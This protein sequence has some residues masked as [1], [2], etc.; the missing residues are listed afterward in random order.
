M[1]KFD[2]YQIL[3]IT[4][5]LIT[6][7]AAL[8]ILLDED[9]TTESVISWLLFIFIFRWIGVIFYILLGI[10]WKKN[11]L[12]Q[13]KPEDIFKKYLQSAL[14]RQSRFLENSL[15]T[16]SDETF[17]DTIKTIRLLLS[18][19]SSILTLNNRIKLY[20]DGQEAFNDLLRDIE[21]AEDS[22]HMEFFIWRSDVLGERIKEALIKKALQGL[23]V[24]LI[25]DGLGSFGKIS[26]KYRRELKEN[27]IQF[28]YFL[29]L[30]SAMARLKINY[31]NHRKIVVID[32]RKGYTGGM[33]IGQEYIDGG[34]RFS[35]WRDTALR[36]TGDSVMLLQA[37]FLTDWNSSGPAE[38]IVDSKFFPSFHPDEVQIPMQIAVS[39]PD[40][41]WSSIEQ[42][43]FILLTNANK[44]VWIQSPY[45]VPN[46]SILKAMQASALS[47]IKIHLM[48]TGIPDKR[49][50]F[51]VAQTYFETLLESGV[52]IY[53]YKAGF[54]HSKMM[55]SDKKISTVGTCNMDVRSFHINFEVNS[56]IYD[57]KISSE[58]VD[59][60]NLD[61][62]HCE[63]I[64]L[65][66]LRK[67]GFFRRVRNNFLRVFS[68]IM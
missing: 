65:Q 9:K 18:G 27:G 60:F 21:R 45:F 43:Y 5:I 19:N 28:R 63:E 58:L 38:Y 31:R 54:L 40:S 2:M 29:D 37:L 1:F 16:D 66:S 62:E 51:W 41:R 3:A 25:F 52:R 53:M 13:E 56:V 47:G 64:T 33:N 48:M 22:I 26:F 8:S 23:D 59:R 11:N 10:N 42:L 12:V 50:P 46:D 34:R 68:P 15:N 17:N 6:V 61:L 44:E 49:V 57:E 20:Y 7:A 36:V 32:G 4:S 39:G 55:V 67:R 24:K 14:D 30:N 35:T